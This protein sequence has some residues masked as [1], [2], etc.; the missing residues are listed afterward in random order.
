MHQVMLAERGQDK[1]GKLLPQ[2][3]LTSPLCYYEHK[4]KGVRGLI[5]VGDDVRIWGRSGRELTDKF[6]ELQGL[7]DFIAMP[8][9]I[10]GEIVVIRDGI[11][12]EPAVM[13]RVQSSK[14][15]KIRV[16]MIQN[17]VTLRAFDV[18]EVTGQLDL[19]TAGQAV[20]ALD[21][22][23]VL[24]ELVTPSPLIQVPIHAEGDGEALLADILGSGGEGVMVKRNVGLYAPGKRSPDWFK[25]KGSETDSFV[26]CGITDGT[27]WRVPYFGALL[28]GKPENGRMRYCGSVGS[29]QDIPALDEILGLVAGMEQTECPFDEAPYEPELRS[30]LR[31]ELI[32]EVRYHTITDEGKALWPSFQGIRYDLRLEDLH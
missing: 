14:D 26:V 3:S 15:M 27:G 30:Y 20:G 29:G 2:V 31:P 16:G 28:L 11:E 21:R 4:W 6:P 23:N 5:V 12:D 17:P 9:V 1:T 22:K 19:T 25:V 32:V 10:D 8:A 18:L 13:S 24:K 7:V